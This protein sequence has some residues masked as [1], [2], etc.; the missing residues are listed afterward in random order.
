MDWWMERLKIQ[1][2]EMMGEMRSHHA[3]VQDGSWMDHMCGGI[4]FPMT[5]FDSNSQGDL[6]SIDNGA[7]LVE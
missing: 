4:E 2:E 3:E 1:V 6:L 7:S 5:W